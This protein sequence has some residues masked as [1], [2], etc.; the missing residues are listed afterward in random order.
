MSDDERAELEAE[1]DFVLE[2]LEHID[3]EHARGLLSD[4]EHRMLGEESTV[5]AAAILRRLETEGE[6]VA[7]VPT[8]IALKHKY[9]WLG[10]AALFVV[11]SAG[12]LLSATDDR[13]FN[14][15]A[16]GSIEADSNTLLRRAQ[17][18]TAQGQPAE[19]VKTYD[20]LL[21]RDPDNAVALTYR[22]W[23]VRLAGLPDEGLISVERA[24]V[25]APNYP[26]AHFF[27]GIILLRDRND[28]Q[29]A[30]PSLEAALAR[31]PPPEIAPAMQRAL[32][33]AR[34]QVKPK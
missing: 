10:M 34:A 4:E 31:K 1:R 29:A 24:I 27:K 22:G 12:L 18:Q 16:T 32:D 6:T 3:D 28:P 2:S 5:R 13:T 17:E 14:E 19:A 15:A 20:R 26:D 23:L 7:L 25:V 8:P 30:I 21:K 11:I 9:I 33:D